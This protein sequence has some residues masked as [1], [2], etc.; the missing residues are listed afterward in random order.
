MDITLS[1][2]NPEDIF[3][4][5]SIQSNND[6]LSTALTIGIKALQMSQ[7]TMTGNSYYEPIKEIIEENT[8]ENRDTLDNINDLLIDL[9]QI[10]GTSS[11]KGKLGESLAENTLLKKYPDW[12]I[13]N[14]SS[15]PHESDLFAYSERYGKILYE[16]KFYKSNV[17]SKEVDKFKRDIEN[18]NCKYGIFVSHTSGI[19]NKR[20]IEYERYENHI[21]VYVSCAGLNGHGIELATEFL[22][23]M[24]DSGC[25]DK[26][27][28]VETD[29]LVQSIND[30]MFDLQESMNN[31]S[32]M[33][34]QISEAKSIMDGQMD[35][36][37]KFAMK[38]EIKGNDIYEKILGEV[39]TNNKI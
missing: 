19:C 26:P 21:L 4:I 2:K 9:L 15:N 25:L 16:L 24:I 10:K 22:L 20:M 12:R 35:S 23:S 39:K 18:T 37:Y 32:R 1:I 17:P 34:T 5:N 31:F 30:K 8:R 3:Y 33:R 11:R 14:T 29:K 13:E 27:K 36:L 7:T 6:I 38:Y 28:L